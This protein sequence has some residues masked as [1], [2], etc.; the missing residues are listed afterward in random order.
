M[1]ASPVLEI[2]KA[3]C[4]KLFT[5]AFSLCNSGV[6]F[7]KF[8]SGPIGKVHGVRSPLTLSFLHGECVR[9]DR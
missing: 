1:L 8:L 3:P 7:G 9:V 4:A 2:S 6:C 5:F